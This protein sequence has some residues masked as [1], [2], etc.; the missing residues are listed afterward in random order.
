[1]KVSTAFEPAVIY[2]ILTVNG[3]SVRRNSMNRIEELSDFER[4]RWIVLGRLFG[5]AFSLKNFSDRLA[6]GGTRTFGP[7]T[8]RV[9][10]IETAGVAAEF[11]LGAADALVKRIVLRGRDKNGAAAEEVMELGDPVET[12]GFRIPSQIFI[13]RVGVQGTGS[14]AA[15]SIADVK[16]DPA[17]PAGFFDEMT[18]SI[19]QKM[20]SSGKLEGRVLTPFFSDDDHFVAIFTNWTPEDFRAAGIADGDRVRFSVGGTEIEVKY[21]SSEN[22]VNDPGVYNAGQGLIHRWPARYPM[23]HIQFN[24]LIPRERYDDLKA[25]ARTMAPLQVRKA[26]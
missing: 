18:V 26:G 25:K 21:F 23:Q 9:L 10:R 17:V 22:A 16:I 8:V 14:P 5:G 24:N 2:D 13:S 11:H 6:D 20:V 3:E 7:E 12:A 4:G 19:G 15:Q 1:M